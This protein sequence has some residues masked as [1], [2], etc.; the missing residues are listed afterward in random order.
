MVGAMLA[1]S[2]AGGAVSHGV[3]SGTD[4]LAQHTIEVRMRRDAVD[5]R[6]LRLLDS[7]GKVRAELSMFEG[8]P[9]LSLHD[10]K[11]TARG[12]FALTAEGAPALALYDEERGGGTP[13]LGAKLEKTVSFD[14]IR[15]P[16]EDVAGFLRHETGANIVI[17]RQ[18]LQGHGCLDV[19]LQLHNLK[20][21]D[22]LG[23][24]LHLLDLSY[25]IENN[26]VV[27]STHDRIRQLRRDDKSIQ[28]AGLSVTAAGD[29]QLSL[30]DEMGA[31][32]AGL[33][34]LEGAPGL[35]LCAEERGG[36][37]P[38]LRA[39]LEKP[40]SFDFF[41]T[42]LG[43]VAAFLRD[44]KDLSIV[45]DRQTLQGRGNLEVTLRLDDVK[46]KDALG[47]MVWL[48]DL[49]YMIENNVVLIATHDRIRQLQR[50]NKGAGRAELN[51]TAQGEPRLS[52]HDKK[53]G[54]RGVF[55][56]TA[57]GEPGLSLLDDEGEVRAGLGVTAGGEPLLVP[58]R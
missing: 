40:A 31:L 42:P 52:L 47:W 3:F 38:G 37:T 10:E 30:Y 5:I 39:K 4:A 48:L 50:E 7:E 28:R 33:G 22:A 9:R 57:E 54:A 25:T 27:I 58:P 14:F 12:V 21:K 46:M 16:L 35:A 24:I 17:D 32:R 2:F 26:V 29:P 11:G 19:T 45:L 43:D 56:L 55:A 13:G 20:M 1:A 34:V 36:G 23:W 41:A 53:G 44:H 15:T 6:S 8:G 18:A 51:V 49:N